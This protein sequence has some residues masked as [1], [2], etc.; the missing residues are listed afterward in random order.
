MTEHD[1]DFWGLFAL[2]MIVGIGM[3]VLGR[4]LAAHDEVLRKLMQTPGRE[5]L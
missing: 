3:H 5:D 2:I 4:H 1:R